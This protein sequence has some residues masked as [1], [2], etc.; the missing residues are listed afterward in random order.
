MGGV[1]EPS[2]PGFKAA[3][4]CAGLRKGTRDDLAIFFSLLPAVSSVVF[5]K[6]RFRAA[7]IVW[8]EKRI[9]L[10]DLRGVLVNAGNANACT[11]DAGLKVV[12]EIS[13]EV[14]RQLNLPEG[15]ILVSSTGVIGVPLP[16][17]KILRKLK[18][19]CGNLSR[20]GFHNAARAM[21]TTDR[22]E[23][24]HREAFRVGEKTITI[25]GVA[26]GAGMISPNMG[27]MLA[28]LFTDCWM[29]S[30]TLDSLFK[31]SVERTFNRIIVD[32]DT[33]TNDTAAVFANGATLSRPLRDREIA[34][35][36]EHLFKVMK[37]LALKIVSDG[38]G[39]TRVVKIIVKGAKTTG[40]AEKVAR[41][42][43]TSPLVKTAIFGA[44][45]N[46]GRIVAAAGRAGVPI[47]PKSVEVHVDGL[48]VFGPRM[49]RESR[50][51]GKA[52]ERVKKDFY[53]ITIVLG[54]GPGGY[55]VYTSDLTY[56]YVSINSEYTT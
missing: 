39:A 31:R 30:R 20:D 17:K 55:Y 34:R 19:L 7:P 3:S 41:A 25:F 16:H 15:K 23:K 1:P 18:N 56:E 11:G 22:C 43:G 38:E 29:A 27:T 10:K 8:A 28:Y 40:Q 37:G 50:S 36:E 33:S 52:R 4:V 6:N 53:E 47:E 9:S 12:E 5:T 24:M 26:K 46:W 21:M 2:V 45:L 54:K 13:R 35:F 49:E 51:L 42:V 44:D 32:G 14:S 48:R